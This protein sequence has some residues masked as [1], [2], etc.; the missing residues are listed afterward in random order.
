MFEVECPRCKQDRYSDDP[1]A[2]RIRLCDICTADLTR[3]RRSAAPPPGPFLFAVSGVLL[4]DVVLIALTAGWPRTLG[5]PL[6]VFGIALLAIGLA[7]L[8][9]T[10]GYGHIG[11]V[12]WT[13]ARWPLL[14]TL[15]GSA[16]LLAFFTFVVRPNQPRVPGPPENFQL[17]KSA[18]EST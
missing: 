5:I 12:D 10:I 13:L 1:D 3:D 11:D 4:A 9:R 15:G 6:A 17:R 16:C 18:E 2:G 14:F 7:G 8:R